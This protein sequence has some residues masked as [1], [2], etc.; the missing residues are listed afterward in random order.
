MSFETKAY[1]LKN[2]SEGQCRAAADQNKHAST[3]S[4]RKFH[5]IWKKCQKSNKKPLFVKISNPRG[6]GHP[7]SGPNRTVESRKSIGSI[8]PGAALGF[9]LH[10]TM[11]TTDI[12]DAKRRSCRQATTNRRRRASHDGTDETTQLCGHRHLELLRP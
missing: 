6:R 5:F 2:S 4:Q 9:L 8:A 3:C 10:C 11:Q 1:S 12:N 7:D